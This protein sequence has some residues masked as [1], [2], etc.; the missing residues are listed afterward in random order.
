VEPKPWGYELWCASPRNIAELD[1]EDTYELTLDDLTALFPELLLGTAPPRKTQFPLIAKIIK[2]DE[3]LSVQ[4]HPDDAYAT[5]LGDLFGKEEAWHV[6]E[7]GRDA[8]IYL[9]LEQKRSKA[10]V[11]DAVDREAF[12]FYLH[13]F[14]AQVGDTYHIPPGVVH[15]LGAGTKVYEVSTASERTFRIYDHGRGREL[16]LD[17]ALSVLKLTEE[18]LWTALKK[19]HEL[20]R[21]GEK[22]EAYQLVQGDQ[23]QVQRLRLA[24]AAEVTIETG[25]RLWLVTC[26]L[27]TVTLTVKAAP[28]SEELVLAPLETVVVPACVDCFGLR[29]AGEVLCTVPTTVSP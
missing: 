21:T 15:A 28:V 27:G 23:F 19:E 2:A 9:G 22:F 25:G 20:A 13:G 26:L 3:N 18:G 24:G 6:L 16:H 10:E 4:V 7:A 29:G 12:H 1:A 14:S 11:L 17:D 5:T 8:M